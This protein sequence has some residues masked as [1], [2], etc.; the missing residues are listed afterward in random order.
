MKTLVLGFSMFILLAPAAWAG[1]VV[2]MEVTDSRSPGKADPETFYA[3][4]EMARMDPHSA[5]GGAD[6]AVI[7]RNETMWFVD[8]DK[9]VCQKID[10]EG[11]AELSAQLDEITKQM[12]SLPPE[13]RKM[14]EEMMK[15]KVPGMTEAPPRRVETGAVE[16]VGDY[17][18]TVHSLYSGEEKVWEVCA[19][20]ASVGDEIAEAMGAFRALS[21]FTQ[22]L[23]EMLQQGPFA[24]MIQTPY[25]ELDELGG[26]PVRVRTFNKK[27][28][29]LRESTLKAIT[30]REVEEAVFTVP[31][32]YKVKDLKDQMNKSH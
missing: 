1:V 32:G 28:E 11:M 5:G 18:C 3:Q 16:Q 29:V 25:N 30:Q 8:H 10:K 19:A 13:Q 15:G 9:K 20:D 6:M 2:E 23:Q 24:N 17:T 26:F 14:M 7:F 31:P 4:G 21:R 12:A 22:D 27:G